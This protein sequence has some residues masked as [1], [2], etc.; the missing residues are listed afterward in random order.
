VLLQYNGCKW[1]G[2]K[3]RVEVAKPNYLLK[4]QQEK[5]RE[6]EE[7]AAAEEQR[8]QQLQQQQEEQQPGSPSSKEPLRIP[9]PGRKHKVSTSAATRAWSIQLSK[10]G[11]N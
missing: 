7:E 2:H 3:L 10:W 6:A 1:R 4:L 5:Q 11:P 9:V 8:Q